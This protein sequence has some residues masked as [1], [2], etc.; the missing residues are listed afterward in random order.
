[1]NKV[2]QDIQK[3]FPNI[4]NSEALNV[5]IHLMNDGIDFSAI[6]NFELKKSALKAISV[7]CPNAL[8]EIQIADKANA[9]GYLDG[10]AGV[11]AT[12]NHPKYVRSYAMGQKH[13]KK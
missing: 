7:V 10:F 11:A 3:W 13:A 9:Q 1:M 5:H 4:S 6:N 12:S 8:I 2:T